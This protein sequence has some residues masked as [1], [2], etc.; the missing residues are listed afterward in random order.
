MARTKFEAKKRTPPAYADKKIITKDGEQV[1]VRRKHRK[2]SGT[3][4]MIDIRKYQSRGKYATMNVLSAEPFRRVV[5]EIIQDMGAD[6]RVAQTAM[7]ALQQSTE[8]YM[9]EIFRAADKQ[10]AHAKRHTLYNED[11]RQV[12]ELI[13]PLS[14]QL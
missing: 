4:A 11:V 1:T 2:R 5:R 8:V 6:F 12:L 14:E 10:R 13:K 3:K 9:T 7:A